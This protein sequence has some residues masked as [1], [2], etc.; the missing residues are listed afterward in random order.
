MS[1]WCYITQIWSGL[2]VFQEVLSF[3]R[4]LCLELQ[5]KVFTRFLVKQVF[6]ST[7][8]P[9][10]CDRVQPRPSHE[11]QREQSSPS[12]LWCSSGV[13]FSEWKEPT[14]K[15]DGG[16]LC[17][18]MC[19]RSS[20]STSPVN[21]HTCDALHSWLITATITY[22]PSSL[23]WTTAFVQFVLC[24]ELLTHFRRTL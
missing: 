5:L 24:S 15:Y 14:G 22:K 7:F 8:L 17:F 23:L 13:S 6:L 12:C 16:F 20:Y 3:I 9:G 21:Q 19:C 11:P 18:R 2:I 1:Q 10:S 4:V